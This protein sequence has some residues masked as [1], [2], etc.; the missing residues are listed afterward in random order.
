MSQ[1]ESSR[2]LGEGLNENL[3][4][5]KKVVER[6][7]EMDRKQMQEMR[8]EKIRTELEKFAYTPATENPTPTEKKGKKIKS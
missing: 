4:D 7:L 3:D 6:Q 2:Q 5:V 8:E 1:M